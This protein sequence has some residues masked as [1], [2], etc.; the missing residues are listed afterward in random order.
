MLVKAQLVSLMKDH[1]TICKP[2]KGYDQSVEADL[3]QYI[4]V[5]TIEGE[6]P[7]SDEA[8][9]KGSPIRDYI[10]VGNKI[11]KKITSLMA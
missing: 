4:E 2:S 8:Y 10:K 3:D 6:L 11:L 7:E 1:K 5:T 9:P